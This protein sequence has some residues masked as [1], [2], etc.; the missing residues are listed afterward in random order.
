MKNYVL[1]LLALLLFSCNK[2]DNENNEG[3]IEEDEFRKE[4]FEELLNSG[5]LV[6]TKYDVFL[7]SIEA[8]NELF[9]SN[10]VSEFDSISNS[11]SMTITIEPRSTHIDDLFLIERIP[12]EAAEIFTDINYEIPPTVVLDPDPLIMWHFEAVDHRVDIK[13]DVKSDV[14][15]RQY[16]HIFLGEQSEI[17][18]TLSNEKPTVEFSVDNVTPTSVKAEIKVTSNNGTKIGKVWLHVAEEGRTGLWMLMGKN[19]GTHSLIIEQLKPETWYNFYTVIQD[20][21]LAWSDNWPRFLTSPPISSSPIVDSTLMITQL[22]ETSAKSGGFISE[23]G[24]AAVTRRGVCWNQEGNPTIDDNHTID[25]EGIGAF[26]S[27]LTG[28]IPNKTYYIRA[29]AINE[30]DVSYAN[31]LE[32]TTLKKT[33]DIEWQHTFGGSKRDEGWE[34]IQINNGYILAGF[35]S[36]NDGDVS[37][38]H[39]SEENADFWIAEITDNMQINW[40]K[41]FGGS[42]HEYLRSFIQTSDGGYL[43]CGYSFSNDGDVSNH[44]GSLSNSDGWVC[45]IN[46]TGELMWERSYGGSDYDIINDVVEI[47]NEGYVFVGQSQSSDFDLTGNKGRD[48][49]WLFKTNYQ[50]EILWQKNYGGIRIDKANAI[51][52]TNDGGFIIAGETTSSSGDITSL[53]GEYPYSD[54]WILK[55]SETGTI[56]WE[57][58][59]GGTKS[60]VA[61]SII[62][63]SD[64][65]YIF[66]STARSYDGDLTI[67]YGDAD[68]WITKINRTGDI[69]WQKTFGGSSWDSARKLVETTSGEYIVVGSTKSK[70]EDLSGKSDVSSYFDIWVLS[71]SESGTLNWTET[72]DYNDNDYAFSFNLTNDGGIIICGYTCSPSVLATDTYDILVTKLNIN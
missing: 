40:Q 39:G 27:I 71:L 57:K 61:Y 3:V 2:N 45:K 26:E 48:D 30:I 59:F 38:N 66:A 33:V 54:S 50:G 20:E 24:G 6:N 60:E 19:E 13:Y 49:V 67:F 1:A 22:T 32:F 37:G 56:E 58:T 34:I 51:I 14:N 28:L 63:T 11:T 70:D 65:G 31:Q 68:L 23:N 42:S 7:E 16:K 8:T 52:S 69:E 62:Q 43:A 44:H 18:E 36:S 55:L 12:K 10:R 29:Y 9:S 47:H 5:L 46:R 41:S 53:H 64:G 15:K 21:Y 25:G 35:S 17:I 72:I 4:V